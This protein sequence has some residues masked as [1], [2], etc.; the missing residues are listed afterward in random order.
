MSVENNTKSKNQVFDFN[1][2]TDSKECQ[3]HLFDFVIPLTPKAS[4][5]CHC[6]M[7]TQNDRLKMMR[8]VRGSISARNLTRHIFYRNC[9]NFNVQQFFIDLETNFILENEC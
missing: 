3:K 5:Y 7:S 6:T 2:D 9:R 1:I 4:D 8:A